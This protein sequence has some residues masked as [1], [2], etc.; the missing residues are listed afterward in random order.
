MALA[1]QKI[2]YLRDAIAVADLRV[3]VMTLYQTT[4]DPKW[5]EARFAPRLDRRII[6]EADAGFP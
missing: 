6:A 2:E 3:M 4:G 5:L 1:Q